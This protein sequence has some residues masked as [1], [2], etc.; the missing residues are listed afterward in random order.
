MA[1][2]VFI[3]AYLIDIKIAYR[4]SM[5]VV[6]IIVSVCMDERLVELMREKCGEAGLAVSAYIEELVRRDLGLPSRLSLGRRRE[7]SSLNAGGGDA[8]SE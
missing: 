1:E 6:K 8:E 5:S 7:V 3:F 4:V 2:I